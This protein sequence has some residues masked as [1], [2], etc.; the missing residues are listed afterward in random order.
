[1]SLVPNRRR[2]RRRTSSV[3]RGVSS[4]DW[5]HIKLDSWKNAYLSTSSDLTPS[6]GRGRK[7]AAE[8][9]ENY[10][11][12]LLWD[13]LDPKELRREGTFAEGAI[14]FGIGCDQQRRKHYRGSEVETVIDSAIHA[15]CD[16]KG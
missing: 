8:L 15:T 14:K 16:F 12:S 1:M 11:S 3:K 2:T 6:E 9:S 13:V 7:P 5:S 4:K 10:K